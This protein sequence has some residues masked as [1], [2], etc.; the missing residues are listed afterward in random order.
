MIANVSM[1]ILIGLSRKERLL[2]LNFKVCASYFSFI[3]M[4][5]QNVYRNIYGL[6]HI[7][8]YKYI[9][10]YIYVYIYI[11]MYRHLYI[12]HYFYY[13]IYQIFFCSFIYI[14]IYI[15]ICIHIYYVHMSYALEW[16]YLKTHFILQIFRS[17]FG[18]FFCASRLLLLFHNI[19]SKAPN[20]IINKLIKLNDNTKW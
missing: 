15:Y 12:I 3:S 1:L 8:I 4:Y 11:C 19:Y 2:F 7:Y 16:I 20:K 18:S 9:Y 13:V 5:R 17:H 6:Q 10:I 14:Y